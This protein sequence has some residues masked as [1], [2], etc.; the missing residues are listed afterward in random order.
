VLWRADGTSFPAEYWSHPI[1]RNDELIGAVVTF[2]DITERKQVEE[3]IQE[4]VRRREQF[5]AML[6]HELRNPLAAILSATRLLDAAGWQDGACQEAGQVVERQARHMTRLLDDLLDVS[7]ITRGRITLRPERVDLRDT[8][9]SAIEALHPLMV[10]H[11]IR[12][13]V[14]ICQEELPIDGDAARLHQVQANLLSNATKYSSRGGDVRFELRRERG[15][16]VIRVT[17]HGRGIE[18]ELLP[19]IFDL[20]VQG[21][22]SIARPD[23]GL[24]I[25]LTL[26]RSLVELHHGRVEAYSEGT[27]RGSVFTVYLPLAAADAST[28]A[29]P[30]A[31]RPKVRSIVLVEDQADAR[32]MMELLLTADDRQVETAENGLAGAELIERTRPDLAIV[33]LGLPVLSGFELAKRIRRNPSLN[34][35]RLIALSGYGQDADIQAALDAGFDQHLTKPPDLQRLEEVLAGSDS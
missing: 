31:A 19:R 20:F 5:L 3:E 29:A 24:G 4:G 10:E 15:E 2:L 7:R 6:S 17:D 16:A 26:L 34:G 30:L 1:V 21:D 12:L 8:A 9:R 11:G 33:D 13:T 22:Q 27:N 35:I 23:G 18:A 14:D 28:D 32:R 25:G